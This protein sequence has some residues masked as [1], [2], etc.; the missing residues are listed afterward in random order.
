MITVVP[1]PVGFL[2]KLLSHAVALE[3]SRLVFSMFLIQY[4]L[5]AKSTVD[6]QQQ[7]TKH[8]NVKP[9]N[10]YHV[11]VKRIIKIQENSKLKFFVV[12]SYAK[13]RLIDGF[14]W[15]HLLKN[16]QLRF[17]IKQLNEYYLITFCCMFFNKNANCHIILVLLQEHQ[18]KTRANKMRNLLKEAAHNCS[19][20]KCRIV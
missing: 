2:I 15:D 5:T 10:I 12:N 14:V 11:L 16:K 1:G 18:I 17:F 19:H 9:T 20:W 3:L 7:I 6:Q 4:W 13:Q 8:A